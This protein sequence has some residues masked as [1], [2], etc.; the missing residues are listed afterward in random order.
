MPLLKTLFVIESINYNAA[1]VTF[2]VAKEALSGSNEKEK[3]RKQS[4]T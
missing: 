3:E 4:F 1:S 2:A